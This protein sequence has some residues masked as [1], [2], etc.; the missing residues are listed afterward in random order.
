MV[1]E[2][3]CRKCKKRWTSAPD[4]KFIAVGRQR[5]G[6]SVQSEVSVLR[7]ECRLPFGVIQRYLKWRYG[8]VAEPRRC[9]GLVRGEGERRRNS[10]SSVIEIRASLVVYGDETVLAEETGEMGT[11]GA[12]STPKVVVQL[13]RATR[14]KEVFR[15]E[16]EGVWSSV[17]GAYN[18][19]QGPHQRCWTH[20]GHTRTVFLNTRG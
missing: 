7:E 6:I 1:L 3:T 19:Y 17:Y 16:F 15:R 9:P 14:L 4:W 2:R 20:R 13:S 11:S 12:V 10:S 8:L 18:V 5:I